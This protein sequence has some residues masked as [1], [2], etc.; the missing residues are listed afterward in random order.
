MTTSITLYAT[1]NCYGCRNY[2][3]K[4]HKE[5]VPYTKV[6][7]ETDPEAHTMLKERGYQKAPIVHAVY[8]GRDEWWE[9][10]LPDNV[11]AAAQAIQEDAP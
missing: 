5:G 9:G 6:M 7:I 4:F 10:Y 1:Q 11:I 8:A 3:R 2:V